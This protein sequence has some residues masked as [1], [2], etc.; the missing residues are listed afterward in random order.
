M[1]QMWFHACCKPIFFERGEYMSDGNLY[2]LALTWTAWCALHSFLVSTT[3]TG[4]LKG[5]GKTYYRCH[6]LAFNLIAV[7]TVIVPLY[8]GWRL[9]GDVIFEWNGWLRLVQAVLAGAAVAFFWAGARQYDMRQFLGLQQILSEDD[10]C[11][12]IGEACGVETRGV[13]G[14]VRHPWYCGGMLIIWARDLDA[15]ALVTNLVLTAYFIVG[16]LL[17]ERRLV[18]EIGEDYR[19][20]QREVPMFLPWRWFIGRSPKVEKSK[21]RRV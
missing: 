5:R 10:T 14:L 7:V 4:W 6:R 11:T 3:V 12:T 2:I 15:A 1:G 18:R 13:L 19:R 21:G 9:R 17:E 16:A 8:L 20:Y